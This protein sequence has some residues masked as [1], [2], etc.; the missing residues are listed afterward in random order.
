M[1]RFFVD[2]ALHVGHELVL[3]EAVYHHWCVVLR[4]KLGD[5]AVL[6]NGQGGE[7]E[8]CL[9]Y[10]DKKHALV[11]VDTHH[12]DNR[13]A[14]VTITLV[15]ALSKGERMDYTIQK[16]CEL[17][18]AHI[19]L[20]VTEHSK[21]LRYARDQKKLA[22][23]QGIII[24]ACEQCGLNQIPTI[25]AP[26]AL[27]DYLESLSS[28]PDATHQDTLNLVLAPS[29]TIIPRF[30]HTA[31]PSHIRLLVGAEGGLSP[32]EEQLA[33][34]HG[35]DSWQLG[36]RILRTETAGLVAMARLHMLYELSACQ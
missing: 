32:A 21:R 5:V 9:T 7:Y 25:S 16:A 23:W 20:V 15:Q 19:D 2:E 3:P 10:I 1:R 18:V 13:T 11:C 14:P 22:H 28:S 36:A 8:V 12:P 29:G 33:C 6:F 17:G 31:P 24:A 34:A 26:V 4:A 35:F 30:I 27:G